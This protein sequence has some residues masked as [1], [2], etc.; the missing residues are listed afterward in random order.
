MKKYLFFIIIVFILWS[1]F[2]PAPKAK[3]SGQLAPAEPTQS[4]YS[5]PAAWTKDK[6]II[7]PRARYRIQAVVLSK[8]K[9]WA[10]GEE[11]ALAPYDLALG[12]G[13]MSDATV[14][15]A[16]KISQD[17]RWYNYSWNNFPP[18]EVKNIICHSSN[19]HIIAATKD[20]LKQIKSLKRFDV[21]ILEGYL[22][23][24]SKPD[25][26]NWRT[27]LRRDDTLGGSCEIFWVDMVKTSIPPPNK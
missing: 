1:V 12:W 17:G 20:I 22:V 25:G 26:W 24:V 15:N 13:P 16:L 6:Y 8:R 11:D 2:K 10:N 27:S 9:Y 14:I 23:D 21:V 7:T 3:W 19:N 18:I 4:S 5:L